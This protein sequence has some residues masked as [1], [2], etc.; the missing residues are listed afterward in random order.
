MFEGQNNCFLRQLT[1][2]MDVFA[3]GKIEISAVL[4][5]NMLLAYCLLTTSIAFC[6]F[7]VPFTF[8]GVLMNLLRTK[9]CCKNT[10]RD[11]CSH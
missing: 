6:D 3:T 1:F 7:F 10:T 4:S 2:K 5:E 8:F 9:L 11:E